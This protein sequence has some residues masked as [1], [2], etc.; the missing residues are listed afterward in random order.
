MAAVFT[1]VGTASLIGSFFV[2]SVQEKVR[3]LFVGLAGI[4][5]GAL[6][7]ARVKKIPNQ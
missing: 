2:D 6:N 5:G 7:L 4:G 3:L 1:V